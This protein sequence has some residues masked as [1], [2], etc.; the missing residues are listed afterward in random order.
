LADSAG[1]SCESGR[2]F[3]TD[4]GIN[5]RTTVVFLVGS[6]LLP[7]AYFGDRASDPTFLLEVTGNALPY[8]PWLNRAV[9]MG[10]IA[11]ALAIFAKWPERVP[12]VDWRWF[13]LPVVAWVMTPAIS[14]IFNDSNYVSDLS[15]TLYLTVT[16]GMPYLAG[17]ISFQSFADIRNSFQFLLW[18]GLVTFAVALF[19][20]IFGRFVYETL[21]GNHSYQLDGASKYFGSRPLLTFEDPNQIGMWWATLALIAFWQLMSGRFE[22]LSRRFSVLLLIPVVLFQSVGGCILSA[23]GTAFIAIKSPRVIASAFLIM[24]GSASILFV[25]RGPILHYGNYLADSTALGQKTRDVMRK[26]G[27]YSFGWRLAREN[28]NY[29]LV[30]QR[31]IFGWGNVNFWKANEGKTRPWGFITLVTGAYGVFGLLAWASL[32]LVPCILLLQSG[33]LFLHDELAILKTMVVLFFAHAIDAAVNTAYF[34]AVV[35][36]IGGFSGVMATRFKVKD[37]C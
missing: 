4:V 31:P 25:A 34:L 5:M 7:I 23:I 9:V 35:F 3:R 16:W 11:L 26:I 29:A 33:R 28:D 2:S 18:T 24:V 8:G 13:D 27:V 20:F 12:Q 14:G 6:L 30:Q 19:E 10:P 1:V 32:T 15:Q 37:I 21:Y 17:R 36:W 22:N